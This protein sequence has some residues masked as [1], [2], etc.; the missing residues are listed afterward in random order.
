MSPRGL[1]ILDRDGVLN[2]LVPRGPRLDSPMTRDEIALCAGAA[3]ATRT[4]H[5]AGFVIVIATNQPAAAKGAVGFDTLRDVHAAI[6]ERLRRDGHIDADY[7]CWHRAED[8][9]ECRKPRPG[10]LRRAMADFPDAAHTLWMVGDRPSDHQAGMAVGARTVGI[11]PESST[12]VSRST[13][14]FAGATHVSTSL[15]AAL[16]VLLGEVPSAFA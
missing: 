11:T 7:V 14:D 10:L 6:V 3:E 13:L 1:V 15:H 2:H 8:D 5:R 16:P 9:C 12:A 4:L